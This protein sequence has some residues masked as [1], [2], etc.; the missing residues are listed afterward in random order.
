MHGGQAG[1]DLNV[2]DLASGTHPV[3]LLVEGITLIRP[4]KSHES[5]SLD[6]LR[7]NGGETGGSATERRCRARRGVGAS[8]S[9]GC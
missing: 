4:P 3:N 2:P 9:K 5:A 7:E 8:V 1:R 6:R